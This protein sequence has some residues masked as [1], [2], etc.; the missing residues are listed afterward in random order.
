MSNKK[1]KKNIKKLTKIVI[2]EF[3]RRTSPSI[4]K[5]K[6]NEDFIWSDFDQEVSDKF[7][8]MFMGMLNYKNNLRFDISDSFI[9]ISTDDI[10]SIKT[11]SNMSNKLNSKYSEENYV[12][13]EISKSGF[14]RYGIDNFREY[15]INN[16]S[17][18]NDVDPSIGR[19]S[20]NFK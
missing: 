10:T 16:I 20:V 2:N 1:N 13:L 14:E 5:S 3:D 19:W 11:N 15:L 6:I 8:K 12:K 4:E 18:V 9:S 7:K 17:K